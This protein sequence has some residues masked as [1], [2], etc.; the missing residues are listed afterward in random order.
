MTSYF[1]G[2]RFLG[3][4][5]CLALSQA[6]FA[7][8]TELAAEGHARVSL[9]F[10]VE[11]VPAGEPFR[12]GV[13]F[14]LDPEWHVYWHNPGQAGIA[15]ELTWKSDVASARPYRRFAR[16][17]RRFTPHTLRRSATRSTRPSGSRRSKQTSSRCSESAL[18]TPSSRPISCEHSR[19]SGA[20]SP[21]RRAD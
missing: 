18:S 10:D 12:V 16:R 17:P 5:V 8:E 15:T 21:R 1:P 3:P 20:Q 14:Q 19:R 2:M 4:V 9:V 11:S 6:A 13:R 7:A